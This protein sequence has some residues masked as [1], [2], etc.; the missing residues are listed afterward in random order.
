[1]LVVGAFFAS[2]LS[3]LSAFEQ[4]STSPFDGTWRSQELAEGGVPQAVVRLQSFNGKL[5]GTVLLRGLMRGGEENI[6]LE[7][8]IRQPQRFS[9]YVSFH[10]EFPEEGESEWEVRL[11]DSGKARLTI[12]R[13]N[14]KRVQ[15]PPVFT[16]IQD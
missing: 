16:L 13:D 6:T 12:L 10:L 7:L 5:A 4:K 9:R 14:G 15:S 1:M 3:F 11:A 2:S 8:E